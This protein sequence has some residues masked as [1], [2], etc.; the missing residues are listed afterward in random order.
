MVNKGKTE[1]QL[2]AELSAA[3]VRIDD[4]EKLESMLR[5]LEKALHQ[6]KNRLNTIISHAPFG[7]VIMDEHGT[8]QY[9][10]PKFIELFGYNM[11]AIPRGR[12]W[13]RKAYPENG[14]RRQVISTW[15]ADFQNAKPG[16]MKPRT[17]RVTCRDGKEKTVTFFTVL[18]DTGEYIMTCIDISEL[19]QAEDALR[20]SEQRLHRIIQGSPIPTFV[21]GKDRRVIYWNGALEELCGI[22]AEEV[23]GTDGHWK[24]F[25][26]KERPCMAD[27]LVDR[28]LGDMTKWYAGSIIS[29]GLIRFFDEA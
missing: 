29:S 22:K 24:A 1:E 2:L 8:Y 20:E 15:V 7:M 23:V 26:R 17:F 21:I 14:Y 19:K 3:R 27:L 5:T 6:E 13:F 25:Y 12:E 9:I 10:N 16:E 18:L 4:L 28:N 11:S